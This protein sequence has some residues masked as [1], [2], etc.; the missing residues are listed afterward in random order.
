VKNQNAATK[1]I[2]VKIEL[3]E[4]EAEAFEGYIK[5]GCCD[6]E[7]LIKRA[8]LKMIAKAEN[9]YGEPVYW[10]GIPQGHPRDPAIFS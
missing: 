9:V 10:N 1:K 2:T 7:K 4:K 3:S 5:K 6:R 8:V